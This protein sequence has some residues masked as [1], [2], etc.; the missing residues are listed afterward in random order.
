[1]GTTRTRAAEAT[2]PPGDDRLLP[3][4]RRLADRD[5]RVGRDAGLEGGR[6]RRAGVRHRPPT[7]RSDVAH[8]SRGTDPRHEAGH[9]A[10]RAAVPGRA[11]GRRATACAESPTGVQSGPLTVHSEQA[12]ALEPGRSTTSRSRPAATGTSP[13]VTGRSSPSTCTRRRARRASPASRRA[14]PFPSGP[15]YAAAVPD[16]DR[17]LGLRLRQPGRTDERH[18]RPR[19]PHGLRGR[20]RE[21]ARHR[22]L[23]WRL[24]LLRAAAEPRRLRRDRDDRPPTVGEEPQGRD[25]GHLL[26]RDQPAVHG[27]A[28]PAAAS[29]PSRRCRSSTPRRRRSTRAASS[30]PASRSPGPRSA[31]TRRCPPDRTAGSRGRTSGSRAA[32]RR[33]RPT[34]CCT[35]RR[36]T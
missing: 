34:R 18:R 20:R 24:R 27:P 5:Q 22:L 19:E 35:A 23:G 4:R 15:A 9:L 11:A 30:T 2:A 14:R 12:G 32:T 7:V 21:H 31:S 13:P 10:R 3:A 6:E 28:P 25:D 1:M 17:V 36:P 16:A 29:R 33:A 8:R 26:R